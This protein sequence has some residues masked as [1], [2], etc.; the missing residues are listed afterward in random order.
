M[1]EN[2]EYLLVKKGIYHKESIILPKPILQ[3]Q[4]GS[5]MGTGTHYRHVCKQK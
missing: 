5:M 4:I 1:L 3:L 2:F